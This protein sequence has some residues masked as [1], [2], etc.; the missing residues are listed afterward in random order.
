MS[1]K[2][3]SLDQH[4][5]FFGVLK[6]TFDNWPES[7]AFKPENAEHLRAWLL[8]KAK[9][10]SI[11]TF[12]VGQNEAAEVARLLPIIAAMMLHRYCWCRTDGVSAVAVCVPESIAFDKMEHA[13]FCAL[14]DEVEAVILD[15]TGLKADDL[16]KASEAA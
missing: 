6:A 11:K 12:H 4:R 14:N 16:L 3:R 1:K 8:V 5:R 7:H 15:E 9:H 2:P 13:A 10:S